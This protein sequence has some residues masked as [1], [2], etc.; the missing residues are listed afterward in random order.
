MIDLSSACGLPVAV[1]E[2]TLRL[3]FSENL[4]PVEPGLRSLKAIHDVTRD[5]EPDGPAVLYWMYRDIHRREHEELIRSSGLRF[6]LSVF[7]PGRL[8]S[9]YLKS[10]GHYHPFVPGYPLTYP[11][12]YE[13]ATGKATFLLQKVRNICARPEE[14]VVEDFLILE[15]EAGQQAVMPPGYGHVTINTLN[16]PLVTVNWV[17]DSFTSYYYSVEQTRGFAYYL[18]AGE[19]PTFERNPRYS[20]APPVRVARPRDVPELGVMAGVPIYTAC[21]SN[22]SKFEFV[23]QP[24]HHVCDIWRALDICED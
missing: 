8:G 6:D 3:E 20:D 12:I 14:M 23:A 7:A 17:A 4:T 22:P 5:P 21:I 16:E 13:V 15:A 1:D 10:S 9:E 2:V 19:E 18:L 11:E 24:Q